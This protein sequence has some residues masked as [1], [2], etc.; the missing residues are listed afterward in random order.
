MLKQR[1]NILYFNLEKKKHC[2]YI[3]ETIFVDLLFLFLKN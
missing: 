2:K 3:L 1:P